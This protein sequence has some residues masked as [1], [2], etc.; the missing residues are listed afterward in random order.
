VTKFNAMGS[1]LIYSTYLGGF[2]GPNGGDAGAAIAVDASGNAYVTGTAA[3]RNFPTF[4]PFQPTNH[5]TSDPS[6]N[7]FVTKFN[8]KGAALVYSTYLGGSGG[9]YG[10]DVGKGISVDRSG[11]AYVTG[12]TR[13]TNFPTTANAPQATTSPGP[14]GVQTAFV[15]ELNPAGSSLVYSTYLGGSGGESG[16]AI[17][18]D[19]ADN[20]YVAG[21]T[22]SN[23]FPT[24]K[25][26]QP[27]L[28]GASNAFVTKIS[29]VADSAEP[30]L[31][32]SE[33]ATGKAASGTLLT[34]TIYVANH[35][36]GPANELSI[37]DVTPSGTAFRNVSVTA[38]T[39]TAP[40]VGGTGTVTCK[41]SKL[42]SGA[43]VKEKLFVLITAAA[44]STITDWVSATY[45]ASASCY[46]AKATTKVIKNS[47]RFT[48]GI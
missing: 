19:A 41:V 46:S 9:A 39:C 13:S 1:A 33:T 10:C 15:T 38:G 47:A 48:H 23:N 44:G 6:T 29:A 4:N 43:V 17:A 14:Q 32:V 27:T 35:G 8:A 5:C 20:A 16:N 12:M 37:R 3:S 25:A 42:A 21:S 22:S 31:T 11:N 18:I 34:Y 30:D 24:V 40:A 2:A 36:T 28:Q 45:T 7:V 26:F